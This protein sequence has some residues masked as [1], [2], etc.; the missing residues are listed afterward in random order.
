M[1][2]F[3][4]PNFVEPNV[5]EPNVFEPWSAR[6]LGVLRAASS[7]LLPG[8]ATGI[9]CSLLILAAV[10]QTG[11]YSILMPASVMTLLQRA[12]SPFRSASLA[13]PRRRN[14][15]LPAVDFQAEAQ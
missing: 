14:G 7:L 5:F 2:N 4:E 12:S 11:S 9:V 1:R 15:S 13:E 8:Q 6:V 10:I 3:V